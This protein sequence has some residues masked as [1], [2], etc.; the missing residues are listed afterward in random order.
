[1]AFKDELEDW[2]AALDSFC[3][4]NLFRADGELYGLTP[5]GEKYTEQIVTIVLRKRPDQDDRPIENTVETG[6]T[7]GVVLFRG[8][9][10]NWRLAGTTGG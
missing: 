7:D 5:E 10:G 3:Q 8:R 6:R 2:S 4:D 1:M 9:H